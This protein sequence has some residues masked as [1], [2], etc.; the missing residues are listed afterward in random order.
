MLESPFSFFISQK[1]CEV[2][3]FR[4]FKRNFF[5]YV[6]L[7]IDYFELGNDHDV[8]VYVWKEATPSYTMVPLRGYRC[9]IFKFTWGVVATRRW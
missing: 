1:P 8:T 2:P 6:A 9:F 5:A 7:K 3:I 4:T